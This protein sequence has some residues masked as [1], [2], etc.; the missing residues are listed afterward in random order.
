MIKVPVLSIDD[1]NRQYLKLNERSHLPYGKQ[2]KHSI[3]TNPI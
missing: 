3:M 2:F 1:P